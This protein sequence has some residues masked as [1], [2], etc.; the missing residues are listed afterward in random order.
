MPRPI[1]YEARISDRGTLEPVG[2]RAAGVVARLQTYR[3]RAALVSVE[4]ERK[5]RSLAANRRYWGCIV[6]FA[7]EILSVTRDVPLSK[8]QAHYV[9]KAAFLGTIDTPLGPVPKSTRNLSDPEFA[10]YCAKIEGHFNSLGHFLPAEWED[11]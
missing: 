10:E 5:R 3:G 7:A 2:P 1:E 9:L 6:P 4:V 8:D 11:A